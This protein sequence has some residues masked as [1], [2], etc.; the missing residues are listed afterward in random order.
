MSDRR[1]GARHEQATSAFVIS[2]EDDERAE[3]ILLL[4][5]ENCAGE[6][7]T[8]HTTDGTDH[9]FTVTSCCDDRFGRAVRGITYLADDC[10]PAGVVDIPLSV[11]V[12]VHVW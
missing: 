10:A 1:S 5:L 8:V 6:I 4:V 11:I 9:T 12:G 7:V 2:V 3:S